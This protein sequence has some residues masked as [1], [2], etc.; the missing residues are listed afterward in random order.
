LL[1]YAPEDPWT[2][3]SSKVFWNYWI[4]TSADVTNVL[5]YR[6]G[7]QLLSQLNEQQY[8]N[9]KHLSISSLT[10]DAAYNLYANDNDIQA[11]ENALRIARILYSQ[12]PTISKVLVLNAELEMAIGDIETALKHW[13]RISAGSKRGSQQWLQARFYTVKILAIEDP[14][15][16]LAVLE[17]HLILYPNYG[18]G[19]FAAKMQ[20]L[21]AKLRGPVV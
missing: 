14:V 6:V 19:P 16:A 21:H 2:T 18:K 11:G 3:A 4:T 12:K 15:T 13:K 5:R 10:A 9:K 1:E 7:K 8:G 20:Q 17:Q